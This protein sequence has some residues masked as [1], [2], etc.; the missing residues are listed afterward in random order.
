MNVRPCI[1]VCII[2]LAFILTVALA[3]GASAAEGEAVLGLL[4]PTSG[5]MAYYGKQQALAAE[6]AVE[7]INKAGGINGKKLRLIK[8]DTSSKPEEAINGIKRLASADKV[9]AIAGPL[10]SSCCRVAFPLGN[11][12]GIPMISSACSAPGLAEANRPWA[13]RNTVLEADTAALALKHWAKTYNIKSVAVIVDNKDFVSKSFGKNVVPPLLKKNGIK[14]IDTVS[15]QTG[16]VDFS[17]QVTRVK[18]RNPDGIVLAALANEAAGLARELRRQGMKQPLYGGGPLAGVQYI[19][20]GG[21]AVEGTMLGSGFWVDNPEPRIVAW[22]KRFK[23]RQPDRKPPHQIAMFQY[24][25]LMIM[26][27]CADKQKMQFTPQSLNEDR[28]KM[29]D[30]WS[31]LRNYPILSGKMSMIEGNGKRK[32]LILQVVNGRFKLLN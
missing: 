16:D 29:R 24:E 21:K 32:P 17:A 20:K 26:K 7:D 30:C 25:T 11:R 6:M 2:L 13:F 1:R 23:E 9:P 28:A 15:V 3:G 22:V 27:Q 19:D 31:G 18:G 12:L 4:L 10:L 8:L 5:F 14:L